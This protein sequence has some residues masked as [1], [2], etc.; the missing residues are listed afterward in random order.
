MFPIESNLTNDKVKPY[1]AKSETKKTLSC[2]SQC[3]GRFS[4]KR[5]HIPKAIR[6]DVRRPS[7]VGMMEEYRGKLQL[8]HEEGRCVYL[9]Q[10]FIPVKRTRMHHSPRNDAATLSFRW[11]SFS[12]RLE[13][14][15]K[16]ERFLY[17]QKSAF[18]GAVN[19]EHFSAK[20]RSASKTRTYSD[21]ARSA[22]S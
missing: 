5:K 6:G 3:T 22:L 17:S 1:S 7:V 16:T 21:S 11:D 20:L 19:L 8:N 18:V 9:D 2:R 4:G 12:L 10:Y 13:S 14:I 15:S